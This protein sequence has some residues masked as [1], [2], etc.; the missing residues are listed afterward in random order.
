MCTTKICSW[1]SW[2]RPQNHSGEAFR[3]NPFSAPGSLEP[4]AHG[5]QM[6]RREARGHWLGRC[7]GPSHPRCVSPRLW[8]GR[9]F[10]TAGRAP[11]ERLRKGSLVRLAHCPLSSIRHLLCAEHLLSYP[12]FPRGEGRCAWHTVG[13]RTPL[14]LEHQRGPEGPQHLGREWR[15]RPLALAEAR[16]AGSTEA[17][18]SFPARGG[19]Q[20]ATSGAPP[21]PQK[22]LRAALSILPARQ[23]PQAGGTRVARQ[24]WQTLLPGGH[25]A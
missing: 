1:Q 16:M 2:F 21:L 23:R 6:Q 11:T 17:S 8:G 4:G 19:R 10:Q 5:D 24:G 15:L 25:W 7:L 22:P 18:G 9:R 20:V 14:Y 12:S 3:V 13:P